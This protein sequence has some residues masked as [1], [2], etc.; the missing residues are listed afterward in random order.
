MSTEYSDKLLHQNIGES[1]DCKM[2]LL[3]VEKTRHYVNHRLSI[4]FLRIALYER[5]IWYSKELEKLQISEAKM[6]TLD[7]RFSDNWLQWNWNRVTSGYSSN[8]W[9]ED[10]GL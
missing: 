3:D 7:A 2:L 4:I 5:E 1:G 10:N 9:I 8:F 6:G